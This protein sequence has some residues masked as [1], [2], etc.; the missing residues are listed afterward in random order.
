[1]SKSIGNMLY[2]LVIDFHSG[3][4]PIEFDDSHMMV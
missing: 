4:W 2:L 1:M 3:K